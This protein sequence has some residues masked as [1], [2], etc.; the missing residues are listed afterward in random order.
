LDTIKINKKL[1]RCGESDSTNIHIANLPSGTKIDIPVHIF[2]AKKA[3]KVLLICAG[4]HGD[5]VNGVEIVRRTLANNLYDNLVEGTVIVIPLINIFGFIN[6]S[7]DVPDGKDVNR[8]FPGSK[9]GSLASQVAYVLSKE[10]FP[11]IDHAID[12]HTGGST[13][14]NYPQIRYTRDNKKSEELAKAFA[15]PVIIANNVIEKSFRQE[16]IK[17]GK[18]TVVFEGGE[19]LRYDGL[20]LQVAIEGIN[21]VMV[22]LKMLPKKIYK[23]PAYQPLFIEKMY[24][25]RAQKS[26]IYIWQKGSGEYVET[27]ESLGSIN[28][29][30]NKYSIP[31]VA[32]KTGFI[33]GHN[34]ATVVNRGDALFHIG[35]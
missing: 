17:Q 18:S 15:P 34:N 1:F 3:G 9:T 33:F 28:D 20:S 32:E 11:I 12:F 23:K 2:R 10:V 5:E 4:L 8:S 6:F 26:G 30:Q 19:S 14:Y 21:R 16:A 27:G 24:W 25:Q 22:H 31:V 35:W 7:R 13:R 29:P